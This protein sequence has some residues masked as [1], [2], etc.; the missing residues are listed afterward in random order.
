MHSWIIGKTVLRTWK[1]R[2]WAATKQSPLLGF[3]PF[4]AIIILIAIAFYLYDSS[5]QNFQSLVGHLGQKEAG[6]FL[7]NYAAVSY[8]LV[9][10]GFILLW[11][12][13]IQS[14]L[15]NR[16]LETLPV[17]SRTWTL[18]HLIPA[19]LLVGVLLLTLMLP[20][21]LVLIEPYAWTGSALFLSI[22]AYILMLA[23]AVFFG[24][25]WQQGIHL[26]AKQL[27]KKTHADL[28]RGFHSVLL[29]ISLL[30]LV[31]LASA[32]SNQT[33]STSWANGLP[34]RLFS[35][36]VETIPHDPAVAFGMVAGLFVYVLFFFGILMALFRLEKNFQPGS[37]NG[38]LPLQSLSFRRSPFFSVSLFELKQVSR[39]F[40]THLYAAVFLSLMLAAGPIAHSFGEMA[41]RLF[42]I[43]YP[44]LMYFGL[45]FFLSIYPLRSRSKLAGNENMLAL[46]PV[47]AKI[48]TSGKMAIY[49]AVLPFF[50]LALY[51]LLMAVNVL[52]LLDGELS[53]SFLFYT[54]LIYAIAFAIGVAFPADPKILVSMLM[55]NLLFLIVSI[56]AFF[57]IQYL[58]QTQS[59]L[60]FVLESLLIALI[61]A[62]LCISVE[63]RRF[64]G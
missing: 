48:W 63:E 6:I 9:S 29:I 8:A 60:W 54:L 31:G 56:P 17:R 43:I 13:A 38:W 55:L 52:P 41:E 18:G 53:L 40:E 36:F 22:I 45:P 24:L 1:N 62:F 4:L 33:W 11:Q 20:M 61:L 35:R 37:G 58:I 21:L 23:S 34:H 12:W 25:C 15:Q 26:A 2:W 44:Q 49:T 39:D 5:K 46:L 57:I 19:F 10:F 59:M 16:M 47:S 28:E 51:D 3:L 32:I 50:T 14:H 27:M 42:Q 30:G 64:H 7:Q